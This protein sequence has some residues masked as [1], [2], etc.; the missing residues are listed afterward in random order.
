MVQ[1]AMCV[2]KTPRCYPAITAAFLDSGD[3]LHP[4]NN[5]LPVHTNFFSYHIKC[6]KAKMYAAC[7]DTPKKKCYNII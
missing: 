1:T 4:Q 2:E 3:K 6:L 5:N 7:N